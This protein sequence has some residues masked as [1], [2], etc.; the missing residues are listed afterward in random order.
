MIIFTS[1]R[2]SGGDFMAQAKHRQKV[3]SVVLS[4]TGQDVI[5]LLHRSPLQRTVAVTFADDEHRKINFVKRKYHARTDRCA[6]S[7]IF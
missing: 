2:L 4:G 5:R 6:E 3:M 1:Y 7:H